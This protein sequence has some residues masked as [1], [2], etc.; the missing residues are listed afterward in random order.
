[1]VATTNFDRE[2][3]ALA[4]PLGFSLATEI[5]GYL[6]RAKVPFAQAHDAAGKCVPLCEST[7]RLLDQL[8]DDDFS[9]IHSSLKGDVR[10]VLSVQGVLASRT[11]VG[12]T[13]HSSF[14]TRLKVV[15]AR[16]TPYV[17]GFSDKA[18]TLST[19]GGS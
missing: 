6:V 18:E 15:T 1:M 14:K 19:I 13:S 11:T 8:T 17:K 2:K 16:T 10:E 3:M 5:A 4:A 12:G 7:G 9:S